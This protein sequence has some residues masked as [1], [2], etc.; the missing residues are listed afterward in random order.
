MASW[1]AALKLTL[2][3]SSVTA[4]LRTVT[5]GI[6]GAINSM[7]KL[8]SAGTAA[9]QRIAGAL[10]GAGDVL[11]KLPQQAQAL[12]GIL[13]G[14][15][16]PMRLAAE[17]ESTAVAFGVLVGSAKEAE[18]VLA[19]LR[20][21]ADSSPFGFQEVASAGRNL[22]AFGIE[23][24]DVAAVTGKLA[25][26]ASGVGAP[27]TEI[28]LLYGKARVSQ[29][30][31]S[32][33]IDQFIGRGV[34]ILEILASITG[35]AAGQIRNMASEGKVTFPLLEQ[36]IN[37][38]TVAGGR[39]SGMMKTM[40]ETTEGRF[41]S[42]KDAIDGVLIK[43]GTPINDALRPLMVD[44]AGM[45]DGLKPKMEAI[46]NALRDA[47]NYGFQ[48][49][50]DGKVGD[51][52]TGGLRA[53]ALTFSELMMKALDLVQQ[54]LKQLAI[55]LK[56]S[57]TNDVQGGY[58]AGLRLQELDAKGLGA[59]NLGD[60]NINAE[61][62][63]ARSAYKALTAEISKSAQQAQAKRTADE[64]AGRAKREADNEEA[65]AKDL[66]ANVARSTA[67]IEAQRKRQDAMTGLKG[68]AAAA[69]RFAMGTIGNLT[70]RTK[71]GRDLLGAPVDNGR[72]RFS[73]L[74]N[75]QSRYLSADRKTRGSFDEFAKKSM[76]MNFD[77]L[78]VGERAAV[79]AA[80]PTM[81]GKVQPGSR[82]DRLAAIQQGQERAK[83]AV[84]G[85]KEESANFQKAAM[86]VL[87]AL[88]S[89]EKNIARLAAP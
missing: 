66:A 5:G 54:K 45:A 7:G 77:K 23:A 86:A 76:G 18:R 34:N 15:S 60:P 39:F 44:L 49:I 6:G 57:L 24:R 78:S 68:G 56:A 16:G 88:P 47:L 89:M 35:I 22:A 73:D 14:I 3:S 30:L 64:Q 71:A 26:V 32:E 19:D 70:A 17:A 58:E 74:G 67:A 1:T 72:G 53:A 55:I 10:K 33:D 4:G 43:L 20:K 11:W 87:Q 27:L 61:A 2:N 13:A 83:A 41:S 31:M 40:S 48:I 63:Q 84:A 85:Q 81:G 9:G 50:R 75:I 28:A 46:G 51:L 52:V 21:I 80:D 79:K 8:A 29:R 62:E 38:L 36:S 42:L 59:S 37:K 65:K 82:A 69:T 12:G 25:D